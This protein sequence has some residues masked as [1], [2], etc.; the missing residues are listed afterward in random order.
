MASQFTHDYLFIFFNAQI[1]A[2]SSQSAQTKG[3]KYKKVGRCD[4]EASYVSIKDYK[5][6]CTSPQGVVALLEGKTYGSKICNYGSLMADWASVF[7]FECLQERKMR[8]KLNNFRLIQV[9]G[10]QLKCGVWCCVT[11]MTSELFADSV[12][13]ASLLTLLGTFN[14]FGNPDAIGWES[15]RSLRGLQMISIQVREQFTT[16]FGASKNALTLHSYLLDSHCRQ[17]STQVSLQA[18]L[19]HSKNR[20]W[21]FDCW[22]AR[23]SQRHPK[24]L[25][26]RYGPSE[27]GRI[28]L[29]R[30]IRFSYNMRVC[31]SMGRSFNSLE[32]VLRRETRPNYHGDRA[33]LSIHHHESEEPNP[34]V[35]FVGRRRPTAVFQSVGL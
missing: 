22:I 9:V 8:R 12:K 16:E 13:R 20:W 23:Q 31:G 32:K 33:W 14:L 15:V 2:P 35:E 27:C 28:R 34:G 1:Q 5:G 10:Y 19:L 25:Y 21:C 6:S 29:A 24:S 26:L 18:I 11:S 3:E 17:V 4:P 7:R 30:R